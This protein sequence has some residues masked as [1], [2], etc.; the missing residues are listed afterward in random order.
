MKRSILFAMFLLL[1][2]LGFAAGGTGTL[3]ITSQTSW[4][5]VYVDEV[6]AGQMRTS[7]GSLT[8]GDLEPGIHRIRIDNFTGFDNWFTGNFTIAAGQTLK[9]Q[10]EPGEFEFYSVTGGKSEI[11]PPPAQ[12]SSRLEYRPLNFVTRGIIITSDPNNA[13]V[14]ANG[15]EVGTTPFTHLN[16]NVGSFNLRLEAPSCEP[17][18]GSIEVRKN[19]I[20]TLDVTLARTGFAKPGPG[21]KPKLIPDEHKGSGKL[22]IYVDH[23]GAEVLVDGSHEFYATTDDARSGHE[24]VLTPGE[25]VI[26][27]E[28][29]EVN[30]YEMTINIVGGKTTELRVKL[31][32]P[33][34]KYG[35]DD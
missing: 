35:E 19:Y 21:P 15:A 1:T 6:L 28:D 14:F 31:E 30:P 33:N 7:P 13:K 16:P 10:A 8:I 2:G 3:I 20:T 4:A 23:W 29:D 26:K 24:L 11:V 32:K 25:H 5:D 9:A 22:L 18:E 17:W 27:V 12:A 34:S